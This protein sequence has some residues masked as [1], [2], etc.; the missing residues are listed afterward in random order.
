[1]SSGAIRV[2]RNEPNDIKIRDVKVFVDGEHMVDLLYGQTSE[3]QVE[4]GLRELLFDNTLI[5][6]RLAVKVQPNR[7]VVIATANVAGGCMGV[8]ITILGVGPYGLFVQEISDEPI[9]GT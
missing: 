6:K 8:F 9:E 1:M 5:K 3:K 7:R 2:V 4:P